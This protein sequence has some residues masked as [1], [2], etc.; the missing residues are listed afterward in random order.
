MNKVNVASQVVTSAE[1]TLALDCHQIWLFWK[2]WRRKRSGSNTE[3][4]WEVTL[5]FEQLIVLMLNIIKQQLHKRSLW[6]L[7]RLIQCQESIINRKK[8]H[9]VIWAMTY[10]SFSVQC[11]R[12]IVGVVWKLA[13]IVWKNSELMLDLGDNVSFNSFYS[14]SKKHWCDVALK[15]YNV[16]QQCRSPSCAKYDKL[17]QLQEF[18]QSKTVTSYIF[19][20]LTQWTKGSKA[21]SPVNVLS[22][23]KIYE[24]LVV[25]F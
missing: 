5:R 25:C 22:L 18:Q 17:S 1:G 19:P 10:C 11:E 21:F 20:H 23:R 2:S 14:C 12:R 16:W 7:A 15:L 6:R 9:R 24:I 13:A 4:S 3:E 8:C